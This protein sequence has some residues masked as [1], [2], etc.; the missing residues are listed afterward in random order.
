MIAGLAVDKNGKTG[1][2]LNAN[3]CHVIKVDTII[4]QRSK[5]M[6]VYG[7]TSSQVLNIATI[8]DPEQLVY[9]GV[10]SKSLWVGGGRLD[11]IDIWKSTLVGDDQLAEFT[12]TVNVSKFPES[13]PHIGAKATIEVTLKNGIKK[14]FDGSFKL[15]L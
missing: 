9:Y 14:K 13:L 12:R 5:R 1:E 2:V 15:D 8:G 3:S 7:C 11:R 4:G 10:G 6:L